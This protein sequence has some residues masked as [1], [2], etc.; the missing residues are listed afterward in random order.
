MSHSF[1]VFHDLQPGSWELAGVVYVAGV[2]WGLVLT[3]ATPLERM[4]LALVWPLG[5]IAFV[6][7]IA[8]LLVASAIAFPLVGIPLLATFALAVWVLFG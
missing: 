3:D 2:I 5:P 8:I 7:T 4:M 1:L 6:V